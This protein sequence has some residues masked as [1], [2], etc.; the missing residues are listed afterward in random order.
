M[1]AAQL[2]QEN[3]SKVLL[4][5]RPFDGKFARFSATKTSLVFTAKGQTGFYCN[6]VWNAV[7]KH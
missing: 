2:K 1:K 4:Q 5:G 3:C 6:G 7:Q